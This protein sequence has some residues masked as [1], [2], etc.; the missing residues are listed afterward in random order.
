M[1]RD[2]A[3]LF[4]DGG[5]RLERARSLVRLL[6][7]VLVEKR[8][9]VV[10]DLLVDRCQDV[11]E[12]DDL[13]P[14]GRVILHVA[15]ALDLLVYDVANPRS[16]LFQLDELVAHLAELP[17]RSSAQRLGD[18]ER[19]ALEATPFSAS[20]TRTVCRPSTPPP[21]AGRARP[22]FATADGCSATCWQSLG[23]TYFA[24]ERLSVLAGGQLES[25]AVV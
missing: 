5:R 3:W 11:R 16:V 6:R 23:S 18:E 7:S 15:G 21:A 25:S 17:K 13:P 14:P 4:L 9:D 24:H 8:A 20:P 2:S 19:L 12:L 22:V 10:E 1:E